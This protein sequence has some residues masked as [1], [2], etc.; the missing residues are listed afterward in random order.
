MGITSLFHLIVF[1][2][3]IMSFQSTEMSVVFTK[4][5]AGKWQGEGRLAPFPGGPPGRPG[6]VAGVDTSPPA[7]GFRG[8]WQAM[9]WPVRMGCLLRSEP[10]GRTAL[11]I[12]PGFGDLRLALGLSG[13][14]SPVKVWCRKKL[15]EPYCKDF[16]LKQKIFNALGLSCWEHSF[17]SAA[18]HVDGQGFGDAGGCPGCSPP[19]G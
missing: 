19:H 15:N 1:T 2:H 18:V 3:H 13:F 9:P 5:K 10:D 11:W 4:N 12:I 6:V 16:A 17:L 14:P 8:R 7:P